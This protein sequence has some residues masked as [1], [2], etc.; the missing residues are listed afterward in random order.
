M[1]D[2]AN[3]YDKIKPEIDSAILAVLEST[4]FI[5]GPAVKQLE[6]KLGEYLGASKTIACGNG[7]DALQIALMALDLEPGNE[8][9]V[10]A[11]TYVA[12]A[13]VI[14][15]L[16]LKP[17]W[18]DV[19]AESFNINVNSLEKAITPQTKALIVVHLFGQCADMETVGRIATEHN[20]FVIEDVA[21]SLGAEFIFAD[22]SKKKA[23]T[24]GHIGCTSFFPSKIL[25]CYG[26]GGAIFTND[27]RLAEKLRMIAN[28]GQ[29]VKYY[30]EII[31]VNSRLDS[32]QAA[33]LAVKL[34]Y[35]DEYILSRR[36]AADL[37][38][39]L[40]KSVTWLDTPHRSPYSSHVFHQY[41][42]KLLETVNRDG[43][44]KHLQEAGIPTMVYYPVALHQQN[45]FK[46]WQDND[47]KLPVSEELCKRVISLPIHT[48]MTADTIHYIAERIISFQ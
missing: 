19:D 6:Y 1:V 17:V 13:E 3:Q 18:V 9:I 42:L 41:T 33:V 35:I 46:E 39:N 28:H 12:C 27:Q 20:L 15:L 21:Q 25:G 29:K 32:I 47:N 38:D 14:A 26:D 5:N 4:A 23:G 8:I 7:T 34:R 36:Q 16:K 44:R 40:L 37:Y 45:A 11:F 43:L 10:P 24:I 2:L 31:G 30:H 22:G 48:E